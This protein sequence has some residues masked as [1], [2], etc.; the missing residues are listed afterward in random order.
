MVRQPSHYCDLTQ[1]QVPHKNE[2]YQYK[3]TLLRDHVEAGTLELKHIPSKENL[4]D[5]FTMGL[6][7]QL[8][9]DLA[10]KL[11]LLYVQGGAL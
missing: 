6:S 8:H 3:P 10:N 7:R 2:T 1:P 5:I 9:Q 11:G 4:A